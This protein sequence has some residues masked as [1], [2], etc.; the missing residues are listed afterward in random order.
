MYW[1]DWNAKQV[2]STHN[3]ALELHKEGKSRLLVVV[4]YAAS[5]TD[6]LLS[7]RVSQV[8]WSNVGVLTTLDAERYAPWENKVQII[9]FLSTVDNC[10]DKFL[11]SNSFQ[12]VSWLTKSD[13]VNVSLLLRDGA[14]TVVHVSEFTGV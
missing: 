9:E 4:N 5:D 3:V 12:G 7:L 1:H 8:P 14:F 6:L 10:G 13:W 11:F 2:R